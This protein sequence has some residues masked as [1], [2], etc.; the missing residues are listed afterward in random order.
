[1]ISVNIGSVV[2]GRVAADIARQSLQVV[3][4]VFP[5]TIGGQVTVNVTQSKSYDRCDV[6]IDCRAVEGEI[7]PPAVARLETALDAVLQLHGHGDADHRH[8]GH[9]LT[10]SAFRRA[11]PENVA[12]V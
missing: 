6:E 10:L 7:G 2:G 9:V 1:M 5:V 8:A 12:W 4:D 11:A 3:K